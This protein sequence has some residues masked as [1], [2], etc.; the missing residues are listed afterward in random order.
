[1]VPLPS[2]MRAWCNAVSRRLRRS[3]RTWG[4][5]PTRQGEAGSGPGDGCVRASGPSL[6]RHVPVIL[7]RFRRVETALPQFLDPTVTASTSGPSTST[8]ACIYL[9]G[10]RPALAYVGRTY[11]LPL[12]RARLDL[13]SL[14][15]R[16]VGTRTF[17]DKLNLDFRAGLRLHDLRIAHVFRYPHARPAAPLA[18]PLP[19]PLPLVLVVRPQARRKSARPRRRCPRGTI[20]GGEKTSRDIYMR[21]AVCAAG[22]G[23]DRVRGQLVSGLFY[24]LFDVVCAFFR[25][26]ACGGV[27]VGGRAESG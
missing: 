4:K 22:P 24:Q 26:A 2:P 13:T 23:G 7:R 3:L 12:V 19:L 18:A 17:L 27:H 15:E 6:S 25:H 8:A 10:L 16:G 14:A 11:S 9:I 1:M 20:L 21:R 5:T